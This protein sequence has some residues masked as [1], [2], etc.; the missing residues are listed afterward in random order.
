MASASA[1]AALARSA[2]SFRSR[3]L[4]ACCSAVS[5]VGMVPQGWP[6]SKAKRF[7]NAHKMG[8]TSWHHPVG[9]GLADQCRDD[10]PGWIAPQEK[11]TL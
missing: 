2:A 8:Q 11:T 1:W 4:A 9:E 7:D 5:T 3:R 10:R 6:T